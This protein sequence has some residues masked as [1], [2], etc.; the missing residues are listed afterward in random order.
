MSSSARTKRSR[1][2]EWAKTRSHAKFNLATS[3]L[4]GVPFAEFPL[5]PDELE[6][7]APGGYGYEPLR[8]RLAQHAGVPEDCVVTAAGTSMANHL[9]MAALLEP[10]DEVLV[11][12]PAYG[13]LLDVAHYLGARVKR[14]PRRFESGFAIDLEELQ[15]A[16]TPA[17]R[18][19]VLTNLHNPSGALINANA[20]LEIGSLAHRCRA[21]VLVDE[22]YLEMLF[23]QAAPFC[24]PMGT[25]IVSTAENPFIVTSSLT[26]VYGLSGLRCGWIL[27]SPALAQRMW[28]LND[29]FAATG[30]HAAERMSIMAL[31]HLEQFRKRARALLTANR[32][33][34]DSFLDSRRDLQ[35]LRPPAGTVV[36][37]RLPHGR[38]PEAFFQLLREKYETTVVPGSFFEMPDHFRIGIGGDTA[39]LRAGLERLSAAL[40][41]FARR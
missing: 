16:V 35:C 17:T 28:L 5:R 24:F 40:N 7:S 6:I 41:E 25:S 26:K 37:P 15:R 38:D 34:L 3:G 23:G 9:A 4:I 32:A 14:L 20:L 30:A 2:M 13:P 27:A 22:V 19:I 1:Y 29:L 36:F 10:G 18:L 11:E 39:A 8:H 33:L 12:Q 21:H 31:D